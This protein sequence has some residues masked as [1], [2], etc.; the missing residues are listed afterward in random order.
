MRARMVRVWDDVLG[1]IT[2]TDRAGRRKN[3]KRSEG[4]NKDIIGASYGITHSW[5]PPS[6]GSTHLPPM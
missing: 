1:L 3:E 2:L 6:T 5:V 4:E